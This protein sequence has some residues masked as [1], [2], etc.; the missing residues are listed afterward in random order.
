MVVEEMKIKDG[1]TKEEA[2]H[3]LRAIDRQLLSI[4]KLLIEKTQKINRRPQ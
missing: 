3:S 2:E 4:R 1:I